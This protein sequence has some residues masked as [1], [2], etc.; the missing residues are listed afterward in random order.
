MYNLYSILK[1][2]KYDVLSIR[3]LHLVSLILLPSG[4]GFELTSCTAFL[5]FYADLSKWPDGLTGRPSTVSTP[6]CRA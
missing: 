4:R 6:A 2:P 1:T 3:K 5:T